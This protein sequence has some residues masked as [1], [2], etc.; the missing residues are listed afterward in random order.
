MLS[1]KQH[2]L[3]SDRDH[4]R[5]VRK[6]HWA[7][8]FCWLAEESEGSGR[9][10]QPVCIACCFDDGSLLRCHAILR[11]MLTEPIAFFIQFAYRVIEGIHFATC[12]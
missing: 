12:S 1:L 3:Q 5:N 9:T 4:G 7:A 2:P 10:H 11:R 8:G 6:C